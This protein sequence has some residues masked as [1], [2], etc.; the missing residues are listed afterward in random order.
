MQNAAKHAAAT[1]IRVDVRLAAGWVQVGIVDDG[2]GFDAA[3]T[4][5][6]RGLANI[7][8]RV[9]SVGGRLTVTSALGRGTRL[10][11]RLPT[12]GAS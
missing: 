9:E 8:D 3:G 7:R 2:A 1:G 6:G 10:D 5:A 4:A 12:T 11:I